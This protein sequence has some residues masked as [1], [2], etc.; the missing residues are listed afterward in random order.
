[1]AEKLIMAGGIYNLFF[2]V[3]HLL[4]WKLFDW[5]NDLASLSFVNKAIMQV[6]NLCLTFAF[7]IFGVLSLV[8]PTQMVQTELG[9]AMVGMIAVFWLLRAIEQAV[10]F[11]LRHWSS[12]VFL[13]IFAAGTCLYGIVLFLP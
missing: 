10:F 3:F 4:F 8:Y 5:K 2:L 9:R 1:M 6:L 11:K 7:F 12:W 13:I